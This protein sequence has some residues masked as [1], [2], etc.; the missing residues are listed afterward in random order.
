MFC[1]GFHGQTKFQLFM[2]HVRFSG[3][4][5]SG[6]YRAFQAE[7]WVGLTWCVHNDLCKLNIVYFKTIGYALEIIISCF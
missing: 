1:V 2:F 4:C 7:M 3:L 5:F 6:L